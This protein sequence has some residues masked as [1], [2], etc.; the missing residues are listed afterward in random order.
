MKFSEVEVIGIHDL[1]EKL[2]DCSESNLWFEI[3]GKRAELLYNYINSVENFLI[4]SI[5]D[6]LE[7]KEELEELNNGNER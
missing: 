1:K 2:R 4:N 3:D 5:G 7:V 6:F